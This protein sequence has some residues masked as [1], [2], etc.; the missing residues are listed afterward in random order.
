MSFIPALN[1]GQRTAIL[2]QKLGFFKMLYLY[3]EDPFHRF[4]IN[5]FLSHKKLSFFSSIIYHIRYDQ[6]NLNIIQLQTYNINKNQ[7]L[8]LG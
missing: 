6:K 3:R 7:F 1:I 2:I 5:I 8:V 4:E